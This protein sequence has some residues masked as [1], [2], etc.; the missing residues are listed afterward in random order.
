MEILKAKKIYICGIGGIGISALARILNEHGIEITGSDIKKTKLTTEMQSENIKIEYDQKEENIKPIFDYFIYTTAIS[1]NHPELKKAKELNI[2]TLT[3]AEALG[4][5]SENYKLIQVSGTHGKSTTT[6]MIAKMLLECGKDPTVIIGTLMKELGNKNFRKGNGDLMIIEGCEYKDAFLNYKPEILV[7]TTIEPDHLDYF[8]TDENYYNSF[9][10]MALKVGEKGHIVYNEKDE[11][12]KEIIKEAKARKNPWKNKGIK[13]KVPG[14]FNKENAAAALEVGDIL[15][16]DKTMA[17]SA[18]ESFSGTWRRMEIKN[19]KINGPIFIDDYGHHPTEIT[20][21]LNAIREENQNKK[22]LCI[23]QPHQ[24]SRTKNY[25]KEFAN[26]FASIDK[27]IITE[28]YESRDSEQD[29]KS[30]SGEI[31]T[32]AIIKNNVKA[33]FIKTLP[34]IGDFLKENA[35]K[36]DIIITMGAGNIN[37]IYDLL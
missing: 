12:T 15:K 33:K 16:L 5:L 23:F 31:L 19:T 24:Y 22:I 29:K 17:K 36:W 37:E 2:P 30:V 20:L 28:I 32:N 14:N 7:F 6:A 10:K 3:Y 4:N 13:P 21:T 11:K 1:E 27:V 8:K 25:L 26:S 18:I 9:V 35:N 34:E